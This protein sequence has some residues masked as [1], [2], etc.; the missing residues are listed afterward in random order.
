[1]GVSTR[2]PTSSNAISVP[3]DILTGQLDGLRPKLVIARHP[4]KF[5]ARADAALPLKRPDHKI[6]GNALICDLANMT[7]HG[8]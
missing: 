8:T 7:C 4:D 3:V 1:M 2:V 5:G 6:L